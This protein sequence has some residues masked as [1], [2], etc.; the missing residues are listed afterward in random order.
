MRTRKLAPVYRLWVIGDWGESNPFQNQ[1]PRVIETVER[2]LP[3]SQ[4]VVLAAGDNFYFDGVVNVTDPLWKHVW[5]DP[6]YRPLAAL[7]PLWIA[8]LGNHDY[9]KNTQMA[10]VEFTYTSAN[11][12]NN[13]SSS[14][15]P[16][17][18]MPDR[19][20]LMTHLF[21][22]IH[23]IVIDTVTLCPS[24]TQ[25]LGVQHVHNNDQKQFNWIETTLAQLRD[26][27]KFDTHDL[28]VVMGHYPIFSHGPHGDTPTLVHHLLPLLQKYRVAM[29]LHGH[30]HIAEWQQ[31]LPSKMSQQ[32][33]HLLCA[34]AVSF[35]SPCTSRTKS[36]GDDMYKSIVFDKYHSMW[37]I[38]ITFSNLSSQWTIHLF[39]WYLD[40][41]LS[42]P[43]LQFISTFSF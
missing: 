17:W 5:Y 7:H 42:K 39:N 38:D 25:S 27:T 14:K 29:Y 22:H 31:P 10:Q 19:Y 21:P 23:L 18:Y 4:C 28:I 20:F 33:C 36:Q 30:D 35:V 16:L 6:L 37:S 26:R 32:V 2:Q 1:I 43:H 24:T 11:L 41:A 3:S 13:H 12:K 40:P 9:Q 34:G 15:S 8:C